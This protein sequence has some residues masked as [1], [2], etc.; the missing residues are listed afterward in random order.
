MFVGL[1]AYIHLYVRAV[2]VGLCAYEHLCA[3]VCVRFL[4]L[5]LR[6]LK[7]FGGVVFL[8]CALVMWFADGF[9]QC[10]LKL[11]NLNAL[12]CIWGLYLCCG[13]QT[14]GACEHRLIGTLE[15]RVQPGYALLGA[16]PCQP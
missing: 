5:A 12:W 14:P 15:N 1:W 2:F 9:G 4:L 13:P 6:E 3:R 8:I 10:A 7:S 16:G 11:R